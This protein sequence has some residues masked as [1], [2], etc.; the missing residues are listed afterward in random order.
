MILQKNERRLRTSFSSCCSMCRPKAF[1]QVGGG[2]GTACDLPYALW[3]CVLYWDFLDICTVK[4][5][6][7]ESSLAAIC[8]RGVRVHYGAP[9]S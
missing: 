2:G 6:E 5:E 8:L 9:N 4:G 3:C 1:L 7:A